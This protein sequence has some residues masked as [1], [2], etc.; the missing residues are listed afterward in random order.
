MA[1]HPFGREHVPGMHEH[2]RTQRLGGG[3]DGFDRRIVQV[4]IPDV[5]AD[6]DAGQ[7]ELGHAALEFRDGQVRVL[8]RD[9]PE[10]REPVRPRGDD[11]GEMIVQQPRDDGRIGCGLVV[12]EHDRHRR[13]YLEPDAG[14]VAILEPDVRVPAVVIDLAEGPTVDDDAR[15]ARPECFELRPAAI[16][17]PR[18]EIR[19]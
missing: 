3:Q 19:P 6:L 7:S 9:R 5:G 12:G 4:A 18:A 1:G 15:P 11:T 10:A 14:P 13:E 17:E 16:S 2:G 8:E